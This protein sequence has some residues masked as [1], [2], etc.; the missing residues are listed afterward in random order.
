VAKMTLLYTIDLVHC[1]SSDSFEQ[2]THGQLS[3]S[4]TLP[5]YSSASNSDLF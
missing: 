4:L 5:R 2:Q 1:L 3:S